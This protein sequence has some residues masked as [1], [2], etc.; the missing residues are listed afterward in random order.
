MDT[1]DSKVEKV[2]QVC[3]AVAAELLVPK[4]VFLN[5]WDDTKDLIKHIN[6]LSSYFRCS[7]FVILRRARDY[8]KITQSTYNHLVE[9]FAANLP[10]HN[11][12]PGGNFHNTLNAKWDP[13]FIVALGNS[14][15]L[16]QTSFSDVY[17]IT[18]TKRG[19]FEELHTSMQEVLYG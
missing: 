13:R 19:T 11:K 16:G 6:S 10:T 15:S 2:E 17:R 1:Q 14:A 3:N 18:G 9:E 12:T 7:K 4:Q 8:K 5:K